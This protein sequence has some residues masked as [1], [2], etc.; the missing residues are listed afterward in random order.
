MLDRQQKGI[1]FEMEWKAFD[2]FSN[3]VRPWNMFLSILELR[4]P[5]VPFELSVM[6]LHFTFAF[7]PTMQYEMDCSLY[8]QPCATTYFYSFFT[9][10]VYGKL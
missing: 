1:L 4:V 6:L 8:V 10:V 7:R 2:M 3:C 5:L 9:K